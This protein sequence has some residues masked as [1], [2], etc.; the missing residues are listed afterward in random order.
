MIDLHIHSYFSDG[1]HTPEEIVNN[2][3]KIGLEAIAITDHDTIGGSIEA[4]PFAEQVGL[5]LVPAV[6]MTT[7]WNGLD[8][9]D[10]LAY[11]V[12]FEHREF[13]N[14]IE[15]AMQ[16]LQD[17]ITDCCESLTRDGYSINYDEVQQQNPR[18]AGGAQVIRVL[19]EKNYAPDYTTAR[20]LLSDAW[21]QARPCKLQMADAI[22]TI[23]DVGGVAV[24]AHPNAIGERWITTN[25]I[26]PLLDAGLGGIEIYHP[27]M[28]EAARLHFMQIA[29]E[30]GLAITGGSD[31]HGFPEG[32]TWLG[33][34]PV[35]YD[36]LETL[37]KRAN[38]RK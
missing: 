2:A 32:F 13:Q 10:L 12:D 5:E 6:E 17:R 15:G 4:R 22:R 27:Y 31:E 21:Q 25:D 34:Q 28:D 16:D 8:N 1:R 29:E 37:R 38:L 33:K 30:L 26:R 24:L 9:I 14:M 35:T 7:H 11:W 23:C 18:Y 36:R 3:H 19:I 20:S